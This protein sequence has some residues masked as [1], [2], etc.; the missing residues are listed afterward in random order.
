MEKNNLIEYGI[1]YRVIKLPKKSYILFPVS[2]EK[3]QTDINGIIEEKQPI[4][5]LYDGKDL[6]KSRF[7][8][9]NC[10]ALDELEFIYDYA[11]DEFFLS[12]YFYDDYKDTLIYIEMSENKSLSKYKININTLKEGKLDVSYLLDNNVPSIILNENSL[13]EVLESNDIRQVRIILEKYRHLVTAFKEYTKKGITKINVRNGK[14]RSLETTRKIET[15]RRTERVI[16]EKKNTNSSSN[17]SRNQSDVSYEG[18]RKAIKEKVFGHDEAIDTF[19]QKLYMNYTAE[20][21]DTV[22]SIL[23]VGPTGTGKTETVKAACEYLDIPNFSVNA[24]NIVPQGIKGMSIEDVILGLFEAANYDEKKAERGLI[25]LDEFD[26]L[27]ESD[28]DIK[29]AVKNILLTFTAG[30]TFP[31]DNDRYAFNFNSSMVQKVY[32]GVFQDIV[33]KPKTLGFMSK[34]I[35]PSLGTEEEMREKIIGKGYFS[36]EELTRISTILGFEE[37]DRETK[38][39]ILLYSKLSEFAK[40]K[41]RYKRQ[42][43]IDLYVDDSYIDAILDTISN[44]AT[45][46]RSVNNYVKRTIDVAERSI[47][48]NEGKYKKLVLTKDTVLNPNKFDMS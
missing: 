21:K 19:A 6:Q 3:I 4:P 23:L 40:K 5:L 18:L 30:G 22:E 46:M 36:L 33:E 44:S 25:F 13:K 26:K 35:I 32:A 45:G 34:E 8:I 12:E 29:S 7:V 39:R 16:T 15:D 37:L 47:L 31:I 41:E 38:K 1:K 14:V 17:K 9:D 24:S 28:M 48:S 10:F 27:N 2:L 11:G 42:F 20:E 43:D